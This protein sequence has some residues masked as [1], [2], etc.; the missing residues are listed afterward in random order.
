MATEFIKSSVPPL[1]TLMPL[2]LLLLAARP[3]TPP[4]TL[5]PPVPET[6]P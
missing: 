1:V 4:P 2:M 5:S 6:A 3:R